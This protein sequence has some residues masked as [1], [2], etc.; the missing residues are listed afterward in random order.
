MLRG[1]EK[2]AFT[3]VLLMMCGEEVLP[4]VLE[5]FFP[6]SSSIFHSELRASLFSSLF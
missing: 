1:G 3:S 6:A 2:E 5:P 4:A